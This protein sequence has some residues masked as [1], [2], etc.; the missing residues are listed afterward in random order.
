MD[1]ASPMIQRGVTESQPFG[2]QALAVLRRAERSLPSDTGM[3]CRT[4]CGRRPQF[5]DG[6]ACL[7]AF[8]LDVRTLTF[9]Q[10]MG[11]PLN[12]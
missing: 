1:V 11:F 8:C 5:G 2:A 4:R 10:L 7:S 12:H 9:C 3:N 6:F